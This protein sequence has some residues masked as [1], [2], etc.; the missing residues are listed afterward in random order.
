RGGKGLA[1]GGNAAY[2]DATK[3]D[4][5]IAALA[6]DEAGAMGLSVGT[7]VGQRD[8]ECGIGRLRARVG[9][10]DAIHAFGHEAGNGGCGAE[11]VFVS[12][13][14][15]GRIVQFGG[16]LADGIND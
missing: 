3:T 8:L 16:L 1:V 9:K 11:R 12:E 5:M 15:A 7:M 10:E 14:E 2:R 6:T 13:L 4:A